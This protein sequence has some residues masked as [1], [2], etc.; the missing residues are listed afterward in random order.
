VFGSGLGS[1][2]E[3]K[4][5][6]LS[7]IPFGS[8][9]FSD[10]ELAEGH[11]YRLHDTWIYFGL[12]LGVVFVCAAYWLFIRAMFS[13]SKD[14]VLWGSLGLLMM[15]SAT[16]S[17]AGLLLTALVAKQL[18]LLGGISHTASSRVQDVEVPHR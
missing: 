12:R 11:F 6:V 18:F 17:I 7:F 3:D 10:H 13:V 8:G 2:F 14:R 16:F 4:T 5:G 9:A 1:G 15:N